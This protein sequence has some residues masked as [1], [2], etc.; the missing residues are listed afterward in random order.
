LDLSRILIVTAADEKFVPLLKGLV[1]SL[2]D[3][4]KIRRE[5]LACLDLGLEAGSREWLRKYTDQV[6]SLR[7]DIS[8]DE[9]LSSTKPYLRAMTARPFLPTYFPGHQTYLWMDADTWLQEGFAIDWHA[10]AAADGH[11]AITPQL[12]RAYQHSSAFLKWRMA[13]LD[14]YY[15]AEA[16]QLAPT[17]LYLNS[18]AF[19]LRADAAHWA[20]WAD[21]F[22]RGVDACGGT[23]CCDQ[24]ALN[25]AVW[26]HRLPVH[27]L[28]ALCN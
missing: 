19:A 23:E 6:V 16:A 28:P 7:W 10:M 25:F 24:T 12:D 18:G 15:G 5:Q 20:R 1:E 13:R 26:T 4:G 27:P 11:L 8:L 22:R 14:A 21:A 3:S 2:F 17:A 9:Q